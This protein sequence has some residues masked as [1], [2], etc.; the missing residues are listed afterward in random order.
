MGPKPL[1]DSTTRDETLRQLAD[2]S[3]LVS[4]SY[5][6]SGNSVLAGYNTLLSE[7]REDAAIRAG[8]PKSR[9]TS[10][11]ENLE[12]HVFALGEGSFTVAEIDAARQRIEK[13][14]VP[15]PETQF[16]PHPPVT[17]DCDLERWLRARPS[18]RRRQLSS[19]EMQI[20]PGDIMAA[21]PA[22]TSKASVDSL[23]SSDFVFTGNLQ[24]TVQASDWMVCVI[25][26]PWLQENI[27]ERL[28]GNIDPFVDTR[29]LFGTGGALAAVPYA[30]VVAKDVTVEITFSDSISF[31]NVKNAVARGQTVQIQKGGSRLIVEGSVASFDETR[32]AI[33]VPAISGTSQVMFVVSKLY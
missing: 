11:V 33:V 4:F 3:P 15:N 21:Q 31:E 28:R 10:V 1:D 25:K 17:F 12:R 19:V 18:T 20:S 23:K 7:M 14:D 24:T 8:S 6:E 16:S 32:H 13:F 22:L 5:I 2:N 29:D 9:D 26:R 30:L 27:L